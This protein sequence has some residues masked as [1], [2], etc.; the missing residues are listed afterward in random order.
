MA[1]G[2]EK[3]A[4][5]G[6]VFRVNPKTGERIYYIRYRRGGRG[7]KEISEPV[8][9][10]GAGMT[11]A[12]AARIRADRIRGKEASNREQRQA[13]KLAKERGI[14]PV[15]FGQLW[16]LYEESHGEQASFPAD[17]S[18]FR[19]YLGPVLGNRE[20]AT[21][22]TVDV[23]TLRTRACLQTSYR[24]QISEAARHTKA[25]KTSASLS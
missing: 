14:G 25:A 3:T 12:K 6:V 4:Y 13:A 5:A 21:L 9:K 10:S 23:D 16:E 11:A 2:G 1:T 7:S 20:A 17:Q 8:G 15:T 18:R 19:R 22:T 24:S